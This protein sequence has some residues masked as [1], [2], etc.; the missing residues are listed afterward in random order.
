MG[1]RK[2][3]SKHFFPTTRPNKTNKPLGTTQNEKAKILQ[4][5]ES[6]RPYHSLLS[7]YM[8]RV[9]DTPDAILASEDIVAVAVGSGGGTSRE[10]EGRNKGVEEEEPSSSSPKVSTSW[11]HTASTRQP[12]TPP[13]PT[14]K[15][16]QS[17]RRIVTP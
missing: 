5:L 4:R 1:V 14:K 12:L 6:F 10:T 13:P 8:W 15:A 11:R 7:Y 2:G 16:R 9:A 3:I 17:P